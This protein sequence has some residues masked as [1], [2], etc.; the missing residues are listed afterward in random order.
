MFIKTKHDMNLH[1]PW[2]TFNSSLIN[3]NHEDSLTLNDEIVP[4]QGQILFQNISRPEIIGHRTAFLPLGWT[5]NWFCNN[6]H[7]WSCGKT[8]QDSCQA[9][10]WSSFQDISISGNGNKDQLPFT[11]YCHYLWSVVFQIT[12]SASIK[13]TGHFCSQVHIQLKGK[14]VSLKLASSTECTSTKTIKSHQVKCYT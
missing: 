12:L 11:H 9:H 4:I 3:E 6:W 5:I 7:C 14:E 10:S 8:T 13:I 2:N 1:K